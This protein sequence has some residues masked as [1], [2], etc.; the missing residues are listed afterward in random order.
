VTTLVPLAPGAVVVYYGSLPEA[1]GTWTVVGLCSYCERCDAAFDALWEQW[2]WSLTRRDQARAGELFARQFG[3]LW[4][5]Y[6]LESENGR[7]T[8]VC[9]SS[10]TPVA[11]N[12]EGSTE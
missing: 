2:Y 12:A 4:P 7:M 8:C 6:E 10:L 3:H 9:R 1:Y 5:R 11:S